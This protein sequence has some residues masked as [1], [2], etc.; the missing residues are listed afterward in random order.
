M[1]SLTM[2]GRALVLTGVFS[3]GVLGCEPPEAA[4]P[5]P[6]SLAGDPADQDPG[7]AVAVVLHDIADRLEEHTHD[8][9]AAIEAVRQYMTTQ[10]PVIEKAVATIE[11]R[12]LTLSAEARSEYVEQHEVLV[13]EA[14]T[15]FAHAQQAFRARASEAQKIELTELLNSLR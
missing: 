7:K 5:R 14:M 10:R 9:A 4:S 15:R 13:R 11:Q 1:R 2:L 6:A 12:T 3:F 8:P